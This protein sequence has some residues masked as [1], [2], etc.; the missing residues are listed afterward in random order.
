VGPLPTG[1]GGCKFLVVAVDYFTKW[2]EVGALATITAGNVRNFLWKS[3]V[4]RYGN[5]YTFVTDNDTQFDCESFQKWCTKLRIKNC[6][7]MPIHPQANMQV[8]DSKT[9]REPR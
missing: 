2:V 3:I 8:S 6:F 4:W 1:K 7:S 9:G 5:P